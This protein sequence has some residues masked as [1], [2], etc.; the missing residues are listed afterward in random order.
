MEFVPN[1]IT[2]TILTLSVDSV[3]LSIPSVSLGTTSDT[4]FHAIKGIPFQELIVLSVQAQVATQILEALLA[5]THHGR[6]EVNHPQLS[7]QNPPIQME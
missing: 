5:L 7:L 2:V 6:R 4:A 3:F 1:V